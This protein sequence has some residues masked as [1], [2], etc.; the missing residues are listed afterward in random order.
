[1]LRQLSAAYHAA[2]AR[3]RPAGAQVGDGERVQ[4]VVSSATALARL[5]R[6]PLI[7]PCC[8][9][10]AKRRV[11]SAGWKRGPRVHAGAM[12]SPPQTGDMHCSSAASPVRPLM[13][14]SSFM[15]SATWSHSPCDRAGSLACGPAING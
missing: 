3:A 8:A 14:Q 10:L 15:R 7:C 1:V 6:P 4:W 11:A 12:S 5:H 13:A 2:H 9:R